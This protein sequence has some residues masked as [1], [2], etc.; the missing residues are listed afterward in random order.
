MGEEH[1]R[2]GTQDRGPRLLCACGLEGLSTQYPVHMPSA[3][4]PMM[5]AKIKLAPLDCV[6]TSCSSLS[7]RRSIRAEKSARR[8]S[9]MPWSMR[10]P[11]VVGSLDTNSALCVALSAARVSASPRRVGDTKGTGNS[12]PYCSYGMISPPPSISREV[13]GTV[14]C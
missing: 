9:F 3:H 1:P 13:F 6:T 5:S 12:V 14:G 7:L 4:M 11:G 10:A 8:L 2:S